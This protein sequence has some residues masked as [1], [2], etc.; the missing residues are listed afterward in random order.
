[1]EKALKD[2]LSLFRYIFDGD[3]K[4]LH[5]ID[6]Y[7]EE[8]L[9]QDIK[10]IPNVVKDYILTYVNTI[11]AA[12]M[13]FDIVKFDTI[14]NTLG[15]NAFPEFNLNSYALFMQGLTKLNLTSDNKARIKNLTVK[16]YPVFACIDKFVN[17]FKDNVHK[18]AL[19]TSSSSS[20]D[21][22]L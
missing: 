11:K 3:K 20:F 19:R 22:L 15:A 14:L 5:S 7:Y 12:Y 9:L 10:Q 17:K 21:S 8:E 2:L 13:C 18:L 1:M 4:L 16:F 6:K